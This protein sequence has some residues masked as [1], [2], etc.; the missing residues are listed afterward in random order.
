MDRSKSG[1]LGF[2]SELQPLAALQVGQQPAKVL[3]QVLQLPVAEPPA[4]GVLHGL[5]T[6]SDSLG[7]VPARLRETD[8]IGPA[9]VR[10][11]LPGD[12]PRLLQP[13][14]GT[15][16]GGGVQAAR[17][18][19]RPLGEAV[20]LQQ[21]GEDTGLALAQGQPQGGKLGLH[22]PPPGTVQLKQQASDFALI[23][24][25]AS[26]CMRSLSP[27]NADARHMRY[28]TPAQTAPYRA[29]NTVPSAP[30]A[31]RDPPAR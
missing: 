5:E 6:A 11:A 19:Q 21:A 18:R 23:H 27:L 3:P 8:Q 22:Q 2:M 26:L 15:G 1:P 7:L 13:V 25:L 10:V 17:L 16:E 24:V 14:Q 29:D 4:E 31:P 28:L 20:P 9:A 12:K 30:A